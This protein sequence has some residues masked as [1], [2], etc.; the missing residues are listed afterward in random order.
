MPNTTSN[1]NNAV[2]LTKYM[3]VARTIAAIPIA[4]RREVEGASC[5][6]NK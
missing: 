2:V 6:R 1:I 3:S 4:I 5:G